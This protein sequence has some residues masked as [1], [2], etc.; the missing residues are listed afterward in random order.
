ML[1]ELPQSLDIL[2]NNQFNAVDYLYSQK[3]LSEKEFEITDT[4]GTLL[5]KKMASKEYTAVEV[6]KAFA[7]RAIIAHQFTNCAVD[8]FIEEGLKQ[9]QERDEYLQK[10]I[11]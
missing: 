3:L 9:A 8:I 10:I 2:T 7:K 6:F 1:I 5:V 4:P 11:N